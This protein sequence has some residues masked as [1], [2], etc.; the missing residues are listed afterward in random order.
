MTTTSKNRKPEESFSTY[1]TRIGN[2]DIEKMIFH[3]KMMKSGN[4]EYVTKYKMAMNSFAGS[5]GNDTKGLD[6][7]EEYSSK[8]RKE[9][10][11][12]YYTP[13]ELQKVIVDRKIRSTTKF[14]EYSLMDDYIPE[15]LESH[16]MFKTLKE[17]INDAYERVPILRA[18]GNGGE[19]WHREEHKK[20]GCP[21][22]R[23]MK[24]YDTCT[25][26]K[27]NDGVFIHLFYF[28]FSFVILKTVC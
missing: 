27:S 3:E 23:L 6:L 21:D 28:T 4:V 24:L 16:Y 26:C 17:F 1:V 13:T 7:F 22:V 18:L 9:E 14:Y 25:L 19:H 15:E 8:C 20:M 2:E 12:R 10:K 5:G 11:S